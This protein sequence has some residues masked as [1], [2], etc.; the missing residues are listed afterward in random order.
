MKAFTDNKINLDNKVNLVQM[1]TLVSEMKGNVLGKEENA[2]HQHCLH[3]Q[4]LLS[5]L[6]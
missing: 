3:F 2:G 6:F 4:H 5:H 1:M